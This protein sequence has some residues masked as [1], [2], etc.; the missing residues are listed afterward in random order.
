M[1]KL[2]ALPLVAVALLV[3]GTATSTAAEPP[4]ALAGCTD[5]LADFGYGADG[6]V[7]A[8]VFV[9]NGA[10]QPGT[11][12]HRCR[13]ITY[14]LYVVVDLNTESLVFTSQCYVMFDLEFDAFS[15]HWETIAYY[16]TYVCA[17]YTES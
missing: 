3:A 11:L 9:N 14:T 5:I 8:D 16:D 10:G 7:Q 6:V 13:A 17:N 2:F 1:K 4:E 15:V 12:D